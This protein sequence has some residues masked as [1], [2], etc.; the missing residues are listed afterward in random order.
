MSIDRIRLIREGFSFDSDRDCQAARDLIAEIDR[1]NR[2]LNNAYVLARRERNRKGADARTLEKWGHI[3]RFC[4][5]A[6]LKSSILRED[7]H[8]H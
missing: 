2:S 1:L 3:I 6:G 7:D 5:E 4:E 8:T